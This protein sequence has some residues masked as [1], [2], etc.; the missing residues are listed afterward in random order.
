MGWFVY[1][2]M[3]FSVDC[4]VFETPSE[5]IWLSSTCS[6]SSAAVFAVL[7][8]LANLAFGGAL[9]MIFFRIFWQK[10]V[11]YI[12]FLS[13][14]FFP[15][16]GGVCLMIVSLIGAH[17][18]LYFGLYFPTS[19]GLVL[20]A[21]ASCQASLDVALNDDVIRDLNRL[22]LSISIPSCILTL[23]L[24]PVDCDPCFFVVSC[25]AAISLCRSI[26]LWV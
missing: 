6:S 3:R 5:N 23:D 20:L 16:L 11:Y 21:C 13:I 14:R 19:G 24:G 25:M 10:W 15:S 7:V 1:F 4:P 18:E 26:F 8:V 9:V 22:S 12:C 2:D 17:T